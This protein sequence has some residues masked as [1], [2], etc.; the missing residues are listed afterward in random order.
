[1]CIRVAI[2]LKVFHII[3]QNGSPITVNDLARA[4][5]AEEQLLSM[6]LSPLQALLLTLRS[7]F[8]ERTHLG[9]VCLGSRYAHLP[10]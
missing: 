5:G 9:W 1:M 6:S 2:D 4:S 10:S 7:P 3:V 8:D